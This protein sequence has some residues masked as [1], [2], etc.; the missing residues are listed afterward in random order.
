MDSY[1]CRC[2]DGPPFEENEE[3]KYEFCRYGSFKNWP[4]ECPI[5]PLSLAKNG[6]FST[7]NA[8]EVTCY[9]CGARKSDWKEGDDPE[10][11]HREANRECPFFT[12]EFE[13]NV[14]VSASPLTGCE[15]SND[16][17]LCDLER[18]LDCESLGNS[19]TEEE[20]GN[21]VSI[22]NENL[23]E[24]SNSSGS[25]GNFSGT[26]V[27]RS[28][29]AVENNVSSASGENQRLP[30]KCQGQGQSG[31]TNSRSS[32]SI[33]SAARSSASARN[34]T[35]AD[36]GSIPGSPDSRN[37]SGRRNQGQGH[38]IPPPTGAA[39]GP[40]RFERNRLAT[41]KKWPSGAKVSPAD[42]AKSGFSY[43]GSGDRVQC[44]FCKG[45][46]RNWEEGDRPHIEHRKHFPRCSLVLGIDSGNVPLAPGQAPR[47]N[48]SNT[49]MQSGS[50]LILNQNVVEGGTNMELLGITTDK[51]KNAQ[52]AIEAQRVASYRNW[53]AYKHQTPEQLAA[54]GFFYAGFSDNVKCFYCNGGLRNW[55][56][57]DDPWHEH[58]RW[59]PTCPYVLSVKGQGYVNAVKAE[60]R[61]DAPILT[62]SQRNA[63][64]STVAEAPVQHEVE[65]REVK[66]RMD[67]PDVKVVEEMGVRRDLIMSAIRRRLLETGDDF[68]SATALIEAVFLMDEDQARGQQSPKS[69]GQTG[70]QHIEQVTCTG[71]SSD[72]EAAG[73]QEEIENSKID[74]DETAGNQLKR[75]SS[76]PEGMFNN[77]DLLKENTEL[78]EQ[79]LCKICMVADANI[80][81]LP[82]GHLVSCAA[83][84]PALQ[85]CPICRGTIKGSVRTYMS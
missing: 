46:L 54:A 50:H 76:M 62:Q 26:H 71:D 28:G 82:C 70:T 27:Q 39:I 9:V 35:D 13:D 14:P 48:S 58:A 20:T 3:K 32:D 33:S 10:I 31:M 61:E 64:G 18:L 85:L 12:E 79:R 23:D 29:S 5:F 42:L 67:R 22:E 37:P 34:V 66:A 4:S 81:F 47:R 6:F 44:V 83:C 65:E 41:F 59:F 11:I 53:P 7:G 15:M 68:P 75:S 63:Q 40:L 55:E 78:K 72:Q 51:P 80:V 73:E 74:K 57:G 38:D 2:I 36:R 24:N 1:F 43:T 60:S 30:G 45:I 84:A 21:R 69:R 49:R 19:L 77:V 25:N 52:F 8:D 17:K 56:K 16:I